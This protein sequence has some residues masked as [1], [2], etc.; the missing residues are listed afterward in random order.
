MECSS[1]WEIGIYIGQGNLPYFREE[2][3]FKKIKVI[4]RRET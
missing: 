1:R 4:L 2:N 3:V